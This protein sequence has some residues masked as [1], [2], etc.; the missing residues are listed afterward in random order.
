M[1]GMTQYLA[2]HYWLIS[3]GIKPS[4]FI[5]V[6]ECITMSFLFEANTPLCG[7]TP[8]CLSI[9]PLVTFLS[10]LLEVVGGHCLVTWYWAPWGTHG[11][12]VR[13]RCALSS[14]GHAVRVRHDQHVTQAQAKLEGT[15][16]KRTVGDEWEPGRTRRPRD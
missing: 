14:S 6:G 1:S 2:L 8:L 15:K 4:R 5:Q 7:E 10:D 13:P 11:R 16:G 3:L 9:H 12:N